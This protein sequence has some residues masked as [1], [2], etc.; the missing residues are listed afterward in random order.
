MKMGTKILIGAKVLSGT[1]NLVMQTNM[2]QAGAIKAI[3]A[4]GNQ[5]IAGGSGDQTESFS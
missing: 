1:L 5:S 2:F 3:G 4:S